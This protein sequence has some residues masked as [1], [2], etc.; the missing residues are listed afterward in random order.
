M[1]LRF[2]MAA[3]APS[4]NREPAVRVYHLG[5]LPQAHPNWPRGRGCSAAAAALRAQSCRKPAAERAANQKQ[6]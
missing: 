4:W 6:L 3:A 2:P 1:R 5:L